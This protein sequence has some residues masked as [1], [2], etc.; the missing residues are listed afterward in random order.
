[1]ACAP[2]HTLVS[3]RG[4]A[5][6]YADVIRYAMRSINSGKTGNWGLPTATV[7][8]QLARADAVLDMWQGGFK[9]SMP[10]LI[11][12]EGDRRHLQ[13]GRTRC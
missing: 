11:P 9:E 10:R 13:G 3:V 1:M 5:S 7:R 12:G 8:W 4:G 6:G 2:Q